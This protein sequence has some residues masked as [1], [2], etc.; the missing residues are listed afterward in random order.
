V[1]KKVV[2]IFSWLVVGEA[3]F[4]QRLIAGF[5]VREVGE[6]PAAGRGVLFETLTINFAVGT[7]RG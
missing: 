5:A 2:V 6:S 3:R 7:R 4:M 1:S